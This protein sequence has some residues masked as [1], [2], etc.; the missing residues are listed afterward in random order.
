MTNYKFLYCK[1]CGNILWQHKNE[2]INPCRFC[3]SELV[4][5]PIEYSVDT[6]YP[7]KEYQDEVMMTKNGRNKFL[8]NYIIFNPDF[9][10][11]CYNNRLKNI[12][13][14]EEWIEKQEIIDNSL[15]NGYDMRTALK[16][17]KDA[18]EGRSIPSHQPNVPHCPTCGSTNVQK[19][20]GM[21]RWLSVGLFGL[22]SSDVGKSM[23]CKKCGY[24]W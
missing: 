7:I 2:K 1:R 11:N 8:Y 10:I 15:A 5:I 4:E 17:A 23:V 3:G 22:A 20:S 18:E 6:T 16:H 19:I 24:K 14:D 12:K 21:K 13:S 9:D